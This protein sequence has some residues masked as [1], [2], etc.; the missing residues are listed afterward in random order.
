MLAVMAV[1]L[2]GCRSGC[3]QDGITRPEKSSLGRVIDSPAGLPLAP[4]RG[5]MGTTSQR[6]KEDSLEEYYERMERWEMLHGGM[7]RWESDK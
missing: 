3:E 5:G 1:L 7:S 6:G 4:S 2:A